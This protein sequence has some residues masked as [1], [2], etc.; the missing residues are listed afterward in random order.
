MDGV[1]LAGRHDP[2]AVVAP[3]VSS[4]PST[5]Q[6][7]GIGPAMSGRLRRAPAAIASHLPMSR[8]VDK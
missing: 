1:S 7:A 2:D 5:R 8:N 6:P 4:P 3:P